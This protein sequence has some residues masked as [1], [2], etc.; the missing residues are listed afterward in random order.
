MKSKTDFVSDYR[1]REGKV[2]LLKDISTIF[3]VFVVV[4]VS[5]FAFY[6]GRLNKIF[7]EM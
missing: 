3:I 5:N 7:N 4:A 1:A 2:S 6:S